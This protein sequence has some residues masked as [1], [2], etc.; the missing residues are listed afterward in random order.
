MFSKSSRQLARELVDRERVVGAEVLLRAVDAG[1]RSV[2]D[3]ALGIARPHEHRRLR[4]RFA[5]ED[6]HG[7]R[8]VEAGQVV[9]VGVL[10]VLVLDVVVA[11]RERRGEQ[12]QRAGPNGLDDAVAPTPEVRESSGQV[13]HR[14]GEAAPDPLLR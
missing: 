4:L 9:E 12:Q 8:L 7:L 10:P 1:A 6:E 2:P 3:L 14:R 13:L 11:D 5:V